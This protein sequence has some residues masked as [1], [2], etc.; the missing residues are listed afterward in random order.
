MHWRFKGAIQKSLSIVPGGT[1][2]HHRLQRRFGDLRRFE[3][4][5]ASKVEDWTIM[6]G[7][8]RGAG[9]P[10]E[11][12]RFL[13]IGT[14]WYPT[15]PLACYVAG[16]AR[17][18]T[19]DLNR[20]LQ[21]DLLRRCVR[22]LG[23]F[24]PAIAAASGIDLAQVKRRHA[25]LRTAATEHRDLRALTEGV[26]V[27]AAPADATRTGLGDGEIDVVFSNSVLEHVPPAVITALYE[28]SKRV[29]APGG[30]MF[31]SVNC[32]D[33]YAYVDRQ[34]GPLN[35]LRYSDRAWARW[36]NR[37]LYQNR[38]RAHELVEG[39]AAC[40]FEIVL[41]TSKPRPERLREL[42]RMRVDPQ[43]LGIPPEKLCITTVDFIGRARAAAK[44]ADLNAVA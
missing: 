22:E 39:A 31:H 41:D 24:L 15:F 26:V 11:G 5:L 35:Y 13:E 16:A 1:W 37:F 6:I 17:V 28:E 23:R 19:Y 21:T 3:R 42:A 44:D 10:V 18:A 36:N 20:H 34:I 8:L 27:Y 32:G 9:M 4:E 7:H 30:L 14:G 12:T 38:L 33:H 25:R 43:F 40:G 2:V 29:L